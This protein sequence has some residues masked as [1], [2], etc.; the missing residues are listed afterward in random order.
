[1]HGTRRV[2]LLLLDRKCRLYYT[3][4]HEPTK[5]IALTPLSAWTPIKVYLSRARWDIIYSLNDI[6]TPF[7]IHAF[8][9]P[10]SFLNSIE[11]PSRDNSWCCFLVC[12][13][14]FDCLP[15]SLEG[16]SLCRRDGGRI[17]CVRRSFTKRS[18]CVLIRD[19]GWQCGH[20]WS[21]L[22][23]SA[24]RK[25]S[26]HSHHIVPGELKSVWSEDDKIDRPCT[27]TWIGAFG[28]LKPKPTGQPG[29]EICFPAYRP[30]CVLPNAELSRR[31]PFRTTS[32]IRC[33]E[34]SLQF[35]T[36]AT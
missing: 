17:C 32:S 23:L 15:A 9:S 25:S 29:I 7:I 27:V 4:C 30:E 16:S 1:M 13:F 28:V 14:Q 11:A 26:N 31:W 34:R 10:L 20:T 24:R 21:N 33:R 8:L 36:S 19:T 5:P 22:G 3:R 18:L 2:I 12:P 6:A 35:I